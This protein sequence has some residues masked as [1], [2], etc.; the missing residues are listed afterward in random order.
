M[1]YP[2]RNKYRHFIDLSG[3]WDFQFDPDDKGVGENWAK[4]LN[5]G[6]PIAVP[7]SWN[8]QFADS[9]DFLEPFFNIF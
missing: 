3:F 1:L 6:C 9:R 2:Q 7:A 4:G 8:D 5:D